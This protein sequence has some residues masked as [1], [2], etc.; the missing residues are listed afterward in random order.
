MLDFEIEIDGQ[1]LQ[2]KFENVIDSKTMLQIHNLF[3]ML[4]NPYIPFSEGILAQSLEVT[5]NHV[6]YTQ[7]YAHY[8]YMGEIYGPNFIG[9]E[10]G[11]T[12]GWRS[13]PGKGS[14]HP[15]GREMGKQ[16]HATLTPHWQIEDGQ[17]KPGDPTKLIEWDFGYN[18]ERHPLAT[19]HWDKVAMQD[20][21][22][23]QKFE[24]GVKNILINRL[25]ELY[26]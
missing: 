26:G 1:A 22:V 14:K 16:G 23:K 4:I 24:Q 8:Q 25:R 10:D 21:N 20:P 3:A 17:Y 18:L 7:P 12:P 13:P 15:T 2:K 5:E 9:W 19:H 11:A 6:R